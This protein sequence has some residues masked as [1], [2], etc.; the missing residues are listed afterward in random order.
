MEFTVVAAAHPLTVW[1][2]ED[3]DPST[4]ILD[5]EILDASGGTLECG[6][7]RPADAGS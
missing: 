3:G 5:Y 1:L 4:M 6:H 7:Q 2:Y